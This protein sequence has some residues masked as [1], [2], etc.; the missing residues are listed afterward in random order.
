MVQETLRDWWKNPTLLET[1]NKLGKDAK[2][3]KV[4]KTTTILVTQ[5]TLTPSTSP[6]T[7]PI[8]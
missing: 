3:K 1:R 6:I 5:I 7:S 8:L 2:R 4:Q